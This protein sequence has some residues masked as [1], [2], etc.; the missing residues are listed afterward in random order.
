MAVGR[1][2]LRWIDGFFL[3]EEAG[4][5]QGAEGSWARAGPR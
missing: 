1:L 2:A 5:R 4:D 3:V